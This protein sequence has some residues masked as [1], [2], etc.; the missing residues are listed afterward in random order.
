MQIPGMYNTLNGYKR[1]IGKTG[2]TTKELYI[3]SI[4]KENFDLIYKYCKENN[5]TISSQV[6]HAYCNLQMN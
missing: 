6:I 3:H 2:T 1:Y 4:K 5:T